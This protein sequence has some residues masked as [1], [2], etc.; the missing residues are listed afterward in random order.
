MDMERENEPGSV[1]VN[2]E[3]RII[4][5]HEEEGFEEVCFPKRGEMLA[6][7]VEKSGAGFL[8]Q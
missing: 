4:S 3:A 6:F 5:F 2:W 1:W 7:A 8:I